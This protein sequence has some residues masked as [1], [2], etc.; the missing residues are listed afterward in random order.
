MI[1]AP[2][3]SVA[4]KNC[5][6]AGDAVGDQLTGYPGQHQAQVLVTEGVD[7]PRFIR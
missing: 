6:L 2:L 5:C 1:S 3:R 4:L 7:L